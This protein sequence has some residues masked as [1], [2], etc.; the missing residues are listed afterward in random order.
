M[1]TAAVPPDGSGVLTHRQANGHDTPPGCNRR[2]APP[3]D[4]KNAHV[5]DP[6]LAAP[7]LA[8]IYDVVEGSVTISITTWRWLPSWVPACSMSA[9][10]RAPSPAAWPACGSLLHDPGLAVP[11]VRSSGPAPPMTGLPRGETVPV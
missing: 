4:L 7:R 11:V 3:R 10:V 8:E 2:P 5:P 9:P 6:L 1:P